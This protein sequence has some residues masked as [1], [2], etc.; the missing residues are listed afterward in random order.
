MNLIQW[1]T[2]TPSET[3]KLGRGLIGKNRGWAGEGG[4]Q[5]NGSDLKQ[6]HDLHTLSKATLS[7]VKYT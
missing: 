2:G 5:E 3:R 4:G 6:M 1:D 7:R